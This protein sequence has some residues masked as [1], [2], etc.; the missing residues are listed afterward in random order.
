VSGSE[1]SGNTGGSSRNNGN[2]SPERADAGRG[3]A[4]RADAERVAD[5]GGDEPNGPETDEA[6]ENRIFHRKVTPEAEEA[7]ESLLRLIANLERCEV[8]DLPPLYDQIDHM[9]EHL[10]TEP[11]PTDAQAELEF[12]YH[13]YRIEL[14]Q[15]GDVKFMKIREE[16]TSASKE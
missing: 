10:F 14:D 8:T 15:T 4:E 11:P 13:G 6:N 12:S 1:N 2:D 3:N 16:S 5:G 9:V 7:N